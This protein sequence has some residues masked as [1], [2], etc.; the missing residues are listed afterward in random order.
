MRP[1][2]GLKGEA[3]I[4]GYVELPPERLNAATPAPFT[5]EQWALLAAAALDDAGLSA[6]RVDGI[7]TSHLGPSSMA[8]AARHTMPAALAVFYP[9]VLAPRTLAHD[10]E[11]RE[12]SGMGTLYSYTVARRP[13]GPHFA[14]AV[15][16]LPAIVEWDEG[17]R[18]STEMVDVSPEDLR[19][20]MRVKP[21]FC[22]RQDAK[23]GEV[24]TMLRY[25]PA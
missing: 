3:A 20:G 23:P 1:R 22:D 21:V 14:D 24:V 11:W 25:A 5:L 17:P 16:Q 10:L 12:I 15:P 13:V 9:R 8:A 7:V 18:F 6:E 2:K 19:V 4:V